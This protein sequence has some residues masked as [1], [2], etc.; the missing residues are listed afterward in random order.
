MAEQNDSYGKINKLHTKSIP[1]I[2][3][4]LAAAIAIVICVKDGAETRYMLFAVLFSMLAF[5]IIGNIIKSVVDRFNMKP[6]YEDYFRDIKD[7]E[8]RVSKK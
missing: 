4:L 7:N 2:L 6:T 8:G 1:V 3:M 5:F